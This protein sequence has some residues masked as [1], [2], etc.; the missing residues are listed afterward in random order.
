MSAAQFVLEARSG[1]SV[2]LNA[3]AYS[4]LAQGT[5]F[6]STVR[7]PIFAQV[8]DSQRVRVANAPH[9]AREQ[10][11]RV[12]VQA[13]SM[14]ELQQLLDA[15]AM[16]C[17]D[18][19]ETGGGEFVHTSTDGAEPTTF[20]VAFAQMGEP[21]RLGATYEV[22]H[23]TVVS[24]SMVVD[25][26]GTG[27]EQVVVNSGFQTWPRVFPISPA[28]GTA[29]APA[30]IYYSA[31]S[32]DVKTMLYAWWP[33]VPAHNLLT[34]GRGDLVTGSSASTA[35]GWSV[36]AVSGIVGAGSSIAR[37]TSVT[38]SAPASLQ[39]V[40]TATSGSGASAIMPTRCGF[41]VGKTF[42]AECWVR[43]DTNTTPVTLRVG[44]PTESQTS[45][46]VALST[47]WQRLVVTWTPTTDVDAAYV[48]VL[49]AS[50][51]A[52]T[53]QIDDVQ[54][55]EGADAPASALGGYG[56]GI[57][58]AL[59]YSTAHAAVGSAGAYFAAQTDA[60]ALL[61]SYMRGSGAIAAN[62]SLEF[63]LLPYLFEP[64]AYTDDE[65]EV[66]IFARLYVTTTQEGLTITTSVAPERGTDFGVRRYSTFRS[67]G[68]TIPLPLVNSFGLY[69]LGSVTLRVDRARPRREWLRLTATNSPVAA[70]LFGVDYL[71]LV[72]SRATARS[73]S[74][75]TAALVPDF[76]SVS[77]S[78]A[79]TK[80]I[81]ADLSGAVVESDGVALT[82]DDGLGGEPLYLPHEGG[83]LLVLP[84]S[85]VIDEQNLSDT[86]RVNHQ[87]QVIVKATPRV[88]LFRQ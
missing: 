50:G 45:A 34:N 59:G 10:Q 55:Y 17:D 72:P 56:P 40:T 52:T 11:V 74:G 80:L 28:G 16:V 30:D 5:S 66:S 87:G 51:V 43:S 83:E 24:V 36:A 37:T 25:P 61:G 65:V 86:M 1:R 44:S 18:I 58:P 67:S 81:R 46:P 15:I 54:V 63:P 4:V 77:G 3:G 53:L 69:Y 82:P 20:R 75:E 85:T 76:A 42:T 62:A 88:H 22:T 29:P 7:R 8:F 23:R 79:A 57:V 19:M 13:A 33:T 48:A 60:A 84:A 38:R 31:S 27:T 70:G 26:Y 68:R 6:G 14:S 49:T 41:A 35:Y 39:L 32:V 78:T 21:E 64:D 9:S 12:L 47:S 71:V 73:I 2:S